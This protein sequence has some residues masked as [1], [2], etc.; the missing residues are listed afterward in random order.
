MN[1]RLTFW[2][3]VVFLSAGLSLRVS[4]G[5]TEKEVE[6]D[7]S[8]TSQLTT[9]HKEW[10]KGYV[11]GPV[12]AL[13]VVNGGA[14]DGSWFSV[15]TRLREVVELEQRFDISGD[16]ILV[17]GSGKGEDF[18]GMGLGQ[19][20]ADRRLSKPYDVYVLANFSLEKLPPKFQYLIMEQVAKGAGLVCVGPSAQDF[21]N[22]KRRIE[23]LPGFLNEGLPALDAKKPGEVMSVYRLGKGRA[24]WLNYPA[25]ALTPYKDFSWQGLAEYDYRM[26]W[27]GRG[28][29]WAASKESQLSVSAAIGDNGVT[30]AN[31]SPSR[32]EVTI[33]NESVQPIQA[34][35][36]LEMR[37]ASDGGKRSLG[38]VPTTVLP[39]QTSHIPVQLPRLRADQYFL[40]A[41]VKSDRG[42]EACGA[43]AFTV[44]SDVGIDKVE[45]DRSFVER[46]DRITGKAALRG[47]PPGNCLVRLR[48]RDS[49]ERVLVQTD[50]KLAPGQSEFTFSY[51]ADAFATILMRAE[52]LLLVN[53]EEV[54]MKSTS[55]TVPNRRRGQF[56]FL[57]WDTPRDVLGYYAWQQM[58]KAGMSVCL[59]GSFGPSQPISALQASDVSLVPYS[60]RILDPK[61][62]NGYMK[63]TC[64][65][66]EPKVTKYVQ[67]IVDNQKA[68]REHGV[69]VY[70]LG[71]EG[72]TLGCCVH[73]ACLAAYRRYLASQ[74]GT[75]DKLNTSWGSE[76]K[77]FD[78]VDLLDHKDNMETG[79]LAKGMWARWYDRQA[80]ARHNLMQFSGRFVKGYKELDPEALTG[81]E[82]TGGFGDDYDAILGTNTFYSPYPSIGDDINRSAAP[83][84]LIRAN[85]MGY[86]KTGDAL[87]DAA[88]R[89]V[90]KGMDSVW[91]WMWTGVGS[92]RGY[93]TPTLDFAPAIQ[94]LMAEMKPVR[95]GLGDLLLQSNM[96]HSGIAVF[97][98]LPSALSQSI[99][100]SREF[101]SP[102]ATHQTWTQL[103]YD[104][105]LDFRYVTS[106][107]LKRGVLTT[108]EFKV[109]L[110]PM[111]QALS[112]EESEAI[113]GFVRAG[114]TVIADIRPGVFDGH[115]KP[116][117]VGALD[118][119]F[120]IQRTGKSAARGSV[121]VQATL[122]ATPVELALDK[123][124]VDAGI[125]AT[126]AKASG[127]ADK[128]PALLVNTSGAG[129]ALLLNFQ[130]M[131]EGADEKQA[132]ATRQFLRSLYAA[133]GVSPIVRATAR[134]GGPLPL[135]ETRVWQNGDA[136]VWGMWRQM[137]CAWFSPT[138][139]TEAGEPVAAK[140]TLPSARHVYD[141]R[142]RKYLGKV[143]EVNPRLRWGRASFFLALPYRIGGV[144]VKLSSKTPKP[145]QILTADLH[146]RIPSPSRERHA[147]YV[148]VLDP[149]GQPAEWSGKALV[150]HGATG[151]VQV[152]IA[153]NDSRGTWR[154]RATELFS[155]Q[156]GEATW[157]VR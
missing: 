153:Y 17:G 4:A 92:Y 18:L 3:T 13:F 45:M 21:M 9:P 12:R 14:Y 103:T 105:G 76:Y 54:E 122:G 58:K 129:K 44:T 60:T 90:M 75:I 50:S 8:L 57:Q 114:G 139:G 1:S 63:P 6:E 81:F 133:T 36:S 148:E 87:S 132:T 56:N 73:P 74:Y 138:A 128:F 112:P 136:V 49:Y 64:W 78:E 143:T 65:N 155:N 93:L 135:A 77:S 83:R 118:D 39:G 37:R 123:A 33:R 59:L 142:T 82:G 79:A 86:S 26:L 134:D 126:T 97:Y 146:L 96:K 121:A 108:K 107:M 24:V 80:F 48:L 5:T 32:G 89:M 67:E 10:G 51:T 72:V 120:G 41:V 27:V 22:P 34:R 154:L 115:C 53:G 119:V 35:V 84:E 110:L 116:L 42:V 88:W 156:T 98:N 152:P 61:D 55:F 38:V 101:V 95:C 140:V 130:L 100:N 43:A 28:I 150:L 151:R 7:N 109:L 69:F 19:K 141:L 25:W 131:S 2:R 40:D 127:Q 147:V 20:R 104:L 62:D 85:W 31:Q 157:S 102:D 70:S 68:H 144:D 47:T 117:A 11:R 15:D 52:A 94:D 111:S 46:G 106:A 137:Q 16:A 91:Y 23:P 30:N 145:G 113:R 149:R 71:D 99:E 125:Q 124:R 29:L 66:D